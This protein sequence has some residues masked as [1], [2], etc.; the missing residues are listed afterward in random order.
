MNAFYFV[1]DRK[2]LP[3][4][5]IQAKRLTGFFN[6]DVHIFFEGDSS[7]LDITKAVGERVFLHLNEIEKFL[8]D[9]LPASTHWPKIVYGRIFAPFLLSTYTRLIY[10]DADVFIL[11]GDDDIW[12]IPLEN[13]LGAVHDLDVLNRAPTA[14][15]VRKNKPLYT[16]EQ[17]LSDIGVIGDRY[18]NSGVLVIDTKLWI[19]R[20]WSAILADYVIKYAKSI[21]MFDQDFLNHAQQGLWSELSP[22]WNYQ[23]N[24][25]ECGVTRQIKP[26]ILHFA[27][28]PKPWSELRKGNINDLNYI[29]HD[30]FEQELA[31]IN[32]DISDYKKEKK[33]KFFTRLKKIL[34]KRMS[35]LAG[36]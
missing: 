15:K 11:R 19:E 7:N 6:A 24:I 35:D 1:V 27:S 12:N 23:P 16:K 10:L 18:F 36:R 9:S 26:V 21:K 25:A 32:V 30:V 4:A 13:G 28:S 22:R 3:F 5:L 29:F 8:P 17:W 33:I 20:D 14:L 34:R 2:F 31:A